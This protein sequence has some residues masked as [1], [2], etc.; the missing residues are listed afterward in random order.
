M[1]GEEDFSAW[2]GSI[3]PTNLVFDFDNPI[4]GV[5]AATTT[6]D[7]FEDSQTG[8]SGS[9]SATELSIT[10]GPLSPMTYAVAEIGN[11]ATPLG[12][13]SVA[14]D[15]VFIGQACNGDALL[16]VGSIA[17]SIAIV[18][19]GACTFSEKSIN[20]AAAGATAVVIANNQSSTPWSGLRIWDY[21]DS[22][23]PV[24]A[25][26]FDTTCSASTA[27]TEACDENGTYSAHNVI[28]ESS[29]DK[30]LAYVSWYNDGILVLDIS[31]PYNPV[32]VARYLDMNEDGVT[33]DFWGIYKEAGEGSIYASDRHGGL[34][35][36]K[37]KGKG[38]GK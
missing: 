36:L 15:I 17:G 10:A 14:G 6:G 12:A 23:N 25:S 18:R 31:D 1:E 26:T 11:N 20:A 9:V 8:S 3:A 21:S 35:I 34:Y 22:A 28:V 19:R 24:L 30:V 29:D 5:G 7:A 38:S 2:E 32:E 33:N 37:L 13:T 4:P 16:N 27:P